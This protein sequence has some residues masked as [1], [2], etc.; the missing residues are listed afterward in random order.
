M[1]PY[2]LLASGFLTGKYRS[3]HALPASPRAA[4]AQERYIHG[5]GFR[6][7]EQLDRIAEAHG[8]TPAQEALAWLMVR[9]GITAPFAS[10]TSAE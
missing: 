10:A 4:R 8:A 5:Q 2:M 1:I 6:V 9:P 7:V 3:G